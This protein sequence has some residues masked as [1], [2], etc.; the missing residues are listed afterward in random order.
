VPGTILNPGQAQQFKSNGSTWHVPYAN[1]E[2]A[3]A[4]TGFDKAIYED[5]YTFRSIDIPTSDGLITDG[6]VKN[7]QRPYLFWTNR[8]PNTP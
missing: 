3:K 2:C 4:R 5:R 8:R 6:H 1:P 7:R